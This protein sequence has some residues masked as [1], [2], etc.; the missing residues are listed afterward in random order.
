MCAEVNRRLIELNTAGHEHLLDLD[1]R[2]DLPDAT[3]G[4][5]KRPI[6]THRLSLR[7]AWP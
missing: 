1:W 5:R 4:V 6:R 7:A 3:A 2:M